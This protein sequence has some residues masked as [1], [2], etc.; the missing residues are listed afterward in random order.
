M[1]KK[2]GGLG[3]NSFLPWEQLRPPPCL[4]SLPQLLL[5]SSSRTC[6]LHS[7]T[8]QL[9]WI[10]TTFTIGPFKSLNLLFQT[11]LFSF[12]YRNQNTPVPS[13]LLSMLCLFLSPNFGSCHSFH[14]PSSELVSVFSFLQSWLK[15][16][17]PLTLPGPSL[18]GWSS[19]H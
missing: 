5:H 16:K 6:M 3:L 14:S 18:L 10:P 8:E 15:V 11:Y 1:H 9:Q 13:Q 4:L 7:S 12:P 17:L 19:P 2:D